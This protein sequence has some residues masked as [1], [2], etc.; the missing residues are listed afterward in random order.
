[1]FNQYNPFLYQSLSRPFS[2]SSILNG[3]QR[4]LNIINQTI[5]IVREVRPIVRNARVLFSAFN[6]KDNNKKDINN[7][8]NI[9]NNK[10]NNNSLSFF[11]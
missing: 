7:N 10:N 6:T 3:T 1:M 5:P 4:T 2:F 8:I 11:I 9:S